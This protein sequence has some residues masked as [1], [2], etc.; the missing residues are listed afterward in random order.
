MEPRRRTERPVPASGGTRTRPAA[1]VPRS[2]SCF[3]RS[4][5]PVGQ[6][7]PS[8]QPLDLT[9]FAP[10]RPRRAVARSSVPPASTPSIVTE[11][12]ARTRAE[13][14]AGLALRIARDSQLARRRAG[15]PRTTTATLHINPLG[16]RLEHRE[17]EFSSWRCTHSRTL[18][19]IAP[20]KRPVDGLGRLLAALSI[21][22]IMSGRWRHRI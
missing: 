7:R 22:E 8:V 5:H 10:R 3:S 20:L 19:P 4:V 1:R 15:A 21:A 13:A 12:R 16:C 18:T 9:R 14:R 2:S 11:R 17:R 6:A